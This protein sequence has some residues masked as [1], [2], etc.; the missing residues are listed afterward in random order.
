MQPTTWLSEARQ[1]LAKLAQTLE[2]W[3]P[4]TLYGA[5]TSASLLPLATVAGDPKE[6]LAGLIGGIGAN[7]VA[8]QLEA[9]KTRAGGD[10]PALAKQLS[11]A[12]KGDAHLRASLDEL[13]RQVGALEVVIRHSAEAEREATV[14]QLARQ[15]AKINS[16]LQV[17]QIYVGGDWL[18]LGD[19]SQSYVA[20]GSHSVVAGPGAHVGDIIHH[21]YGQAADMAALTARRQAYLHHLYHE[22]SRL[23]LEGIDRKAAGDEQEA[24]I[25]LDAIYTALLTSQV[26]G[27]E[28]EGVRGPSPAEAALGG[29]QERRKLSAVD[30]L[31]RHSRLVLL[32]APGSGKSTFVN[33]VALCLAGQALGDS[34]VNLERLTAPLPGDG[35]SP[36]IQ[37]QTPPRQP[38]AHGELI[39]LRVILRHL[40][41]YGLPTPN[42]KATANHLW[43]YMV[44]E[45]AAASLDDFADELKAE[46]R[47]KGGLL[48]LDG[49]DE[50]PDA[51]QQREQLKAVISAFAGAHPQCRILVTSRP[52]AYQQEN[53]RLAGFVEA[54]LSPFSRAQINA[55]VERWYQQVAPLR[56][57]RAA[58]AQG[59]A[60]QLTGA[61]LNNPRLHALAEQPLLLTLMASLHAWHGGEL[62]DK[63]ERL[64]AEAVE[65]LLERWEKQRVERRRDG[66]QLTQPSLQ[67]YLQV[68]REAILHLLEQIAY[69]AH[70]GQP[71]LEG[72]ADIGRDRL[73]NALLEISNNPQTR[74]LELVNYLSQRAGL[75]VAEGNT[76]FRF[77]HRTFQEYLAARHLTSPQVDYPSQIAELVRSDP[78]R[79]RE[80]ALLAAAK[81]A[82]GFGSSVWSMVDAFCQHAPGDPRFGQADARGAQLAGQ[83]LLESAR[84]EQLNT[85]NQEKLQRVR[86]GLLHVMRSGDFAARERAL[87]G[88]NLAGLGDPR[89]RADAWFLPDEPLLGFVAIPAGKFIMGSNRRQD[90]DAHENETPQHEVTLPA[91]YIARYPV[92][93]GQFGAFV[94]ATGQPPQDRRS[95]ADPANHPVR[96]VTWYEATRYGQW[97]TQTLGKWDKTPAPLAEKLAQGWQFMLPSEAEWERAARGAAGRRYPWGETPVDPNKANY[98]ASGLETTSAVG[99]FATGATPEGVEELLGNVWEWT[100][101]RYI[102]YPYPSERK[103]QAKR[104]TLQAKDNERFVLRGGV[105]YSAEREMRAPVRDF[106]NPG[107]RY[108]DFGLRLAFGSAPGS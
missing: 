41:A 74:P 13:L 99:C 81:A 17:E 10:E 52:Y 96:Y 98:A 22:A 54:T 12:A 87:A 80:V 67:E 29:G 45:L 4:S 53:W 49:L 73:V 5:I 21:H 89:W 39:P 51:D 26:E 19:I 66:S 55:F 106:S 32:G 18:T 38:W 108:G 65:L 46:L 94:E 27:E 31:N 100:R 79:W 58:D 92:T 56:N 63:R 42:Q 103:E 61:I 15:F 7:L 76:L 44:D 107:F 97:L 43:Q 105:F 77:P 33:F 102:G 30:Q 71:R 70:A 95:L 47:Q 75:L 34:T 9:W 85:P 78:E 84:L 59:R 104:E 88:R 101:S 3:A 48:L 62:P 86:Q 57:Y 2:D 35:E 24:A 16:Q 93:V 90:K 83:A 1:R 36:I 6:L 50:V 68:G 28:G 91:F 72:C 69:A 37:D 64:Y 11:E 60:A 40:A 20:V 82:E 25:P 23:S 14:Q 8:N